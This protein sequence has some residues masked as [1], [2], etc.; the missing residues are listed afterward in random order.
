VGIVWIIRRQ[1]HRLRAQQ[2]WLFSLLAAGLLALLVLSGGNGNQLYF[3]YYG[4]VGG[5]LLSAEGLRL[6]W[7]T[8]PSLS[9]R[10]RAVVLVAF[11]WILLLAALMAIPRLWT[12]FSGL[13]AQADTYMF[14]YGG[15]I[16]ALV[17]LYVAARRIIGPPR[18]A[19]AALVCGALV[20]VGTF[21]APLGKV[22]PR[23]FNP[24]GGTPTGKGVTPG[25]Y[26]ALTWIRD[27]TPTD[28]VIAVN[29][30]WT[31]NGPFEFDYSAFAQRR[32]FLEG[33]GYSQRAAA[34]SSTSR[35]YIEV[36]Q[37][38]TNPFVDRL[39]I[40]DAA[41]KQANATALRT[42]ENQYGVRY[43][44]VDQVNGYA[45]DLKALERAGRI[46]DAAPG[47]YVIE[48]S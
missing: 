3:F 25:I 24:P 9:G 39:H 40:N 45:T 47:V 26:A 12:V 23:L 31:I 18:W 33:W 32:V 46:V 10:E 29:N 16:L 43:L 28:S 6:A 35:S 8:R 14:W 27:H 37:G 13:H 20:L 15:L 44:V 4:L 42:M 5:Y 30:Q 21:D 7:L 19:A 41:F 17:L 1:G 34:R 48:L 11:G 36:A 2:A 38:K 22:G